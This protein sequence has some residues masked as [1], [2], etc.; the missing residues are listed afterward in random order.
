MSKYLR[1][2]LLCYNFFVTR[3]GT[4]DENFGSDI[5]RDGIGLRVVV[6][7]FSGDINGM[8]FGLCCIIDV[9]IVAKSIE[10]FVDGDFAGRGSEE[11]VKGWLG[12]CHGKGR[13]HDFN[14]CW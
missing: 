8:A 6:N 7:C 1:Q 2:N 3:G 9:V 5:G 11:D 12:R 4:V 14:W 13:R 10:L